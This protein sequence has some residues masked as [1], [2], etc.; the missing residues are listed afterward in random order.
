MKQDKP[1]SPQLERALFELFDSI[2]RW[3]RR[4]AA[5]VSTS[6]QQSRPKQ[7]KHIVSVQR[8]CDSV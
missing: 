2:D 7:Q 3:Q 5:L 1:T 6:G 8:I 4:R